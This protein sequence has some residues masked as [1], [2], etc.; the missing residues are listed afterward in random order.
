MVVFE[1]GIAMAGG[2]DW[3]MISDIGN[4]ECF[5]H[6]VLPVKTGFVPAGRFAMDFQ[7]GA[8]RGR[9]MYARSY[10]DRPDAVS[11]DPVRMP[12]DARQYETVGWDGVFGSLRD[13]SPDYWGRRVI[14]RHAGR[15]ELSE[16]DYLLL[17]PDDRVGA[18]G[19]GLSAEPIAP[20][21]DFNKTLD[22]DR[23]ISLADRVISDRRVPETPEANRLDELLLLGTSMGGARPKAVVEDDDGLWLAKFPHPEDKWNHARVEHAMLSLARRCGIDVAHSRV[24]TVG[25]RDVL[26]VKRFDWERSTDGYLRSRMLSA[27]TLLRP[28]IEETPN[29]RRWWSYPL[30]VEELRRLSA[31]PIPDAQQLFRRMVYNALISNIDDHPRNHAVIAKGDRWE[32]SPAYDLTPS[33]PVSIERRDLAMRCGDAGRYANAENLL[34]QCER[35]NLNRHEAGAIIDTME[36]RVRREWYPVA[37]RAGVSETDCS[38]IRGAFVYP[39]FRYSLQDM[40]DDDG[41]SPHGR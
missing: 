26:L 33:V 14:E 1:P 17:S 22:L 4:T 32:I 27:F 39:G 13:A 6:I 12:L 8:R 19:F 11:I 24:E 21:R 29:P 16:I 18:L 40:G 25:G 36:K 15:P 7:Q 28:E 3:T 37:R 30:L 5:V 38:A 41:M 31:H 10:L 23:L 2:T 34:S 20:K 35:F 9:F